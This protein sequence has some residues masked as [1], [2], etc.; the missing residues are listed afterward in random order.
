MVAD[1]GDVLPADLVIIAVGVVPEVSLAEAAGIAL[2]NGILAD[3]SLRTSVP[4]I[5]AAG[6]VANALHPF[7]GKHHRSEHWS[8]ALNGGKVAA[9]AML[10]RDASLD[11]VPYFYTDQFDVSM[12]YSGFPAL[13]SGPP[14]IHGSSRARSSSPSGSAKARGRRHGV[15]LAAFRQA[16]KADQALISASAAVSPPALADPDVPLDRLLPQD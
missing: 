15:N 11:T 8:D 10:G 6:D 2:E 4:G 9:R 5:F 12:E 7:T 13:V 14:T 3:A 16:A 1:T